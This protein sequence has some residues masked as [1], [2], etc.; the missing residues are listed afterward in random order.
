MKSRRRDPEGVCSVAIFHLNVRGVSLSRGSSAVKSA[1]YQ[2][3]VALTRTATGER[4]RYARAERVDLAAVVLPEG[5]PEALR[6]RSTLW[7]AAEAADMGR[8]GSHLVA[9][10]V[11][12]AIPAELSRE[13]AEA[14]VM[15][16]AS[17]AAE[18][19]HAVDVAIHGLGTA[20]PH[21]HILESELALSGSY[22][23]DSASSAFVAPEGPRN[24]KRYL[25]RDSEGNEEWLTPEEWRPVKAEWSKVYN[26]E[27][28]TRRTKAEARAAGLNPTKDRT[29]PSPVAKVTRAGGESSLDAAKT[30]LVALRAQWAKEANAA[31]EAQER[32][33]GVEA[34][35]YGRIDHRSNAERGLDAEPTRHEGY[36]VAAME[37]RAEAEAR[38]EGRRY[39]PSTDRRAENAAIAARNEEYSARVAG[40]EAERDAAEASARPLV[41]TTDMLDLAEAR[42]DVAAAYTIRDVLRN[43]TT[44]TPA[45]SVA[46]RDAYERPRAAAFDVAGR[47]KTGDVVRDALEEARSAVADTEDTPGRGASLPDVLDRLRGFL[48]RTIAAMAAIRSRIERE[49]GRKQTEQERERT[50]REAIEEV[51][52]ARERERS[53]YRASRSEEAARRLEEAAWDEVKAAKRAAEEPDR[54]PRL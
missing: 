3:G 38:R 26:Y 49:L 31:I 47:T 23:P 21:A 51:R 22:D 15:G 14:L 37:A 32:E 54:L 40:L 18:S 17:R 19:G 27:D 53:D 30:E 10:R 42:R 52:E 46:I 6:D 16:F 25:C 29:S 5:A 33:D 39:E 28:G 13:R 48:A 44:I 12:V 7:N 36:A 50:A 41:I 20:N 1:A 24:E 11:E 4:C 43:E 35:T 45:E 34:G 8:P 9:R 2:S